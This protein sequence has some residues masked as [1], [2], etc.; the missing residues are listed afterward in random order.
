MKKFN[1]NDY[2]YIQITES[3]FKHLKETVGDDYIKNCINAEGYKKIINGETWHRLQ[4]HNV[5]SL[6]PMRAGSN[7][8]FTSNVMF[9]EEHLKVIDPP[10]YA[11]FM[12]IRAD[13]VDRHTEPKLG[14]ISQGMMMPAKYEEMTIEIS[15][16]GSGDTRDLTTEEVLIIIMERLEEIK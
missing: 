4:A 5:F 14:D 6:L 11:K 3:G 8:L 1:I 13:K 12:C 9:D 16:V 7:L 15:L 10:K 2:M